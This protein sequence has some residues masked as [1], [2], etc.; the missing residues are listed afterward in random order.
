[1]TVNNSYWHF[2]TRSKIGVT[3]CCLPGLD[4]R[5]LL[6][7]SSL[8]FSSPR[9]IALLAVLEQPVLMTEP[10]CPVYIWD[11]GRYVC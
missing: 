4:C 11:L 10:V 8:F 2:I 3:V 6:F 5:K 7:P 1:M 9:G